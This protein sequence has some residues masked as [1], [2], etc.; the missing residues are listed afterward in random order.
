MAF[1][2]SKQRP[3]DRTERRAPAAV[4]VVDDDERS[5]KLL[6]NVLARRGGFRSAVASDTRATL[7]AMR[8]HLPRCVVIDVRSGGSAA[9]LKVLE[10]IRGHEDRRISSARV[11]MCASSPG[12]RSFS[13]Q[14]GADAFVTHPFHADELVATVEAVLSIPDAERSQHRRAELDRVPSS[15]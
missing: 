4:L 8:Q 13:F 15:R 12:T 1:G 7:A 6:S 14:S 5:A 3:W 10:A 11:V 9:N 2:R